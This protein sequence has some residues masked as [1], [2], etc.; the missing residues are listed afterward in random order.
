MANGGTA[1]DKTL[2]RITHL[3]PLSRLTREI[4]GYE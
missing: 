2:L 3:T 4:A 1:S